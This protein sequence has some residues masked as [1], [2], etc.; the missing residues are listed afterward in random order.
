ME[1]WV[2][3]FCPRLPE[4]YA[5]VTK[6]KV[7]SP[8]GVA[9][10]HTLSTNISSLSATITTKLILSVNSFD[11]DRVKKMLHRLWSENLTCEIS[12]LDSLLSHQ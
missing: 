3:V 5:S 2:C 1:R 6:A 11:M 4:P 9:D 8:A 12:T 10:P 7:T